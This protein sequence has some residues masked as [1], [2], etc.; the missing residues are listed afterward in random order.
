MMRRFAAP[1]LCLV[2]ML[3]VPVSAGAQSPAYTAP[4]LAYQA[5]DRALEFSLGLWLGT[6]RWRF[7]GPV[8]VAADNNLLMFDIRYQVRPRWTLAFDYAGGAWQGITFNGAPAP[9][10][11][12]G[13]VTIASLDLRYRWGAGRVPVDLILGW[14]YYRARTEDSVATTSDEAR[15][16]GLRLGT[17]AWFPLRGPWSLRGA[18]AWAPSMGVTEVF[19]SGGTPTTTVY[20][21]SLMDGQIA[22]RYMPSPRFAA[23]AGYRNLRIDFRRPT[24]ILEHTLDG[25]FIH[26]LYRQ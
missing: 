10:S 5:A 15:A 26:F 9:P 24:D 2:V 20:N 23:E 1:L 21:G 6:G 14:Q 3:A 7:T 19:T 16:G 13:N 12:S 8:D 11:V 4:L 17:E 25:F 18:L 22:L